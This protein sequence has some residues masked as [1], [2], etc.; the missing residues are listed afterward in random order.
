M[1]SPKLKR[2]VLV[3]G[4]VYLLEIMVIVLGQAAGLSPVFAVA[5]SFWVGLLVSFG[6]HKL[7]TFGDRRLHHRV[8][9][10]QLL[11]FAGLVLFNF[12]F[13]LL[14]T[15]LL[16]GVLPTVLI[17]T[18]A[19][20]LTTIWNFYLYHTRIFKSGDGIIY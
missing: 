5:L 18:I 14:A 6:L 2:Y 15:K 20:G 3:G 10:P 11:A 19:I 9:L 1:F 16:S 13:T 4:S 7:I 8:V 17:R 12:G